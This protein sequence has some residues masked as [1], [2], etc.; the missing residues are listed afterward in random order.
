MTIYKYI[1]D[2]Y[3]CNKIIF[4]GLALCLKKIVFD[5]QTKLKLNKEPGWLPTVGM[6]FDIFVVCNTPSIGLFF[7]VYF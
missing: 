2:K 7:N 5:L 6:I 4:C 1:D 3:L